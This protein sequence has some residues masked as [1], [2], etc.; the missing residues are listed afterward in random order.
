MK[1]FGVGLDRIDQNRIQQS[2]TRFGDRL[3][4]KV[5]SEQEFLLYVTQNRSVR[6]LANRFVVKEAVAKAL[7]T[8]I[9]GV[10]EWQS[11]STLNDEWGAP[12]ITLSSDLEAFARNKGICN[13]HVSIT[14]EQQVS[15]AIVI[16]EGEC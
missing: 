10:V 8:G 3:A 7:R 15:M 11:I 4:K 6:F 12:Y 14:D 5:L 1:I 13:W 16:A 9:R 2:Q